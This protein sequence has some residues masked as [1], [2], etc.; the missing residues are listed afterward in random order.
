[1]TA[2]ADAPVTDD[3]GT[4]RSTI[5]ARIDR[6]PW[7]SFHT[8]L[9]I[10]LG[11]AWV[12][13]G[14]E[15]TVASSDAPTPKEPQ[16]PHMSSSSVGLATGTVYLLGEVFGALIFGRLSDA[17]GRRKL[18]MFTLGVYLVGSGLTAATWNRSA[19]AVR[20]LAACRFIAGMGIGGESA[21]INS[22]I[23]ELIPAHY[24][25]R[26][27]IAVNGTYWAG[28]I[29][30]TLGTF[31]FLNVMSPSVGWRPAFLPRPVLGL[32]FIFVR[33]HLPESP[34]WQVMHGY[35]REAEQSIG[36]IEHEVEATGVD[37]PPIDEGKAIELKPTEKIGY[38]ALA[39]VL[40]KEYPS[41]SIYGASLMITQ[42]F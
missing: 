28:A 3:R 22:A 21:A 9:V 11:V 27:D 39:R 25:G 12:L 23:D 34:R 16:A 33:R 1:M 5:P 10:A 30:G 17:W 15:I 6:L 19:G 31:I 37:L 35:E 32:V 2:A 13:D 4:I 8:R 26:V 38:F 40:F 41:R 36:Y 29:L 7:S 42:S 24:R 18:F 20:F 14:L